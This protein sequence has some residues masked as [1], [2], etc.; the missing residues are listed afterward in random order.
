LYNCVNSLTVGV[1]VMLI[2]L[3]AIMM[4]YFSLIVN[5]V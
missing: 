3:R 5:C 4:C 1:T 2:L